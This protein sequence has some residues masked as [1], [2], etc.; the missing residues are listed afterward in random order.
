MIITGLNNLASVVLN[1]SLCPTT[2]AKPIYI[3]LCV[4]VYIYILMII[5]DWCR[6]IEGCLPVQQADQSEQW[7][8]RLMFPQSRAAVDKLCSK[9]WSNIWW[10]CPG[11]PK[12]MYFRFYC[13]STCYEIHSEPGRWVAGQNMNAV[14]RYSPIINIFFKAILTSDRLNSF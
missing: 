2:V 5:S 7:A 11:D 9:G 4:C 14:H 12:N 8:P 13:P 3:H 10:C 6:W 1:L